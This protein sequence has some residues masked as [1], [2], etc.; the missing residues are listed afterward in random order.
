MYFSKEKFIKVNGSEK[1][2]QYKDWVDFYDGYSTEE[3][4]DIG[5]AI[6]PCWTTVFKSDTRKDNIVNNVN[7]VF[8]KKQFIN[9]SGKDL[10]LEY[11]DFIDSHDGCDV[12][13]LLNCGY[14]IFPYWTILKS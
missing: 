9:E 13:E 10:Y 8:S 2:Q 3:L 11:K 14:K 1:Y 5:F 12:E 7:R 4:L 6:L